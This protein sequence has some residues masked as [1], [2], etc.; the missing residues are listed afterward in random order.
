MPAANF[1]RDAF[2]ASLREHEVA[3]AHAMARRLRGERRHATHG[4]HERW[5]RAAHCGARAAQVR[6]AMEASE[7]IALRELQAALDGMGIDAVWPT[8]RELCHDFALYMGGSVLA[9]GMVGGGLD[10]LVFGSGILPGAIA[11]TDAGARVGAVLLNLFGVN[12]VVDDMVDEIPLAMAAYAQG[13][14]QAWGDMPRPGGHAGPAGACWAARQ[15]ARG[16]EILILA[17]LTGI[18]AELARPGK[19]GR[20]DVLGEIRRSARLGPA[21]A[22][23]V[24]QH[25]SALAGHP[26]LQ[27]P[28]A[29]RRKADV[30]LCR[31]AS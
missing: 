29:W 18:V 11:G 4:D 3:L 8:L 24:E 27:V 17:L 28:Y 20:P 5:C 16:H 22:R 9:G 13:V 30:Q 12:A 2:Y 6:T 1:N 14:G 25:G 26:R 31:V 19:W 15:F 10:F 23:W 7:D 21:V